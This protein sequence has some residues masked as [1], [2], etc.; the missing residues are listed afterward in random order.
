[1]NV[2]RLIVLSS[3]RITPYH[4]ILGKAALCITANLAADCPD[5]VKSI[6]SMRPTSSGMSPVPLIATELVLAAVRRFVPQAAVSRC[7]RL[8][9]AVGTRVTS[10]PPHRSVHETFPHTA[11]TSG[12]N[13][14]SNTR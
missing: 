11:P 7:S 10:R 5:R 9:V 3:M 2:R 6:G 4:M 13:A 12:P 1:M 8:H 14:S